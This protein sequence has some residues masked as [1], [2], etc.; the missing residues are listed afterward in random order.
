M[1]I[2]TYDDCKKAAKK[3]GILS[4]ISAQRIAAAFGIEKQEDRELK[5]ALEK[6]IREKDLDKLQD[7]YRDA[8]MGPEIEKKTKEAIN[9]ILEEQIKEAIR[10][11]DL[12]KLQEINDEANLDSEIEKKT[13][14][15]I[16]GIL[17]EQ[18]KEA[19]R[20]KDLDKLQNIYRDAEMGS[21]IEQRADEAI[22]NI[23]DEQIKEAIEKK[24]LDKLREIAEEARN[25]SETEKKA[26]AAISGIL[27]EHIWQAILNKD[28]KRLE[29]ISDYTSDEDV[30]KEA[31]NAIQRFEDEELERRLA[32]AIGRRDLKGLKGVC[33]DADRG[34]EIEKR[35]LKALI[36]MLEE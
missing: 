20:R 14:E 21:E 3:L 2:I 29:E 28:I 8:E 12:D 19:I 7:I 36:E 9:G 24:D 1:R 10:R 11:K 34:S 4:G 5:E 31:D 22:M 17:E 23:E 30:M 15:A 27:K 13:K 6:A 16:N 32:Q 18:I 35:A 25:G 26:E 33:N